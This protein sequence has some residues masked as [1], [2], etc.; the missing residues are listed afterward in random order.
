M[1]DSRQI[2]I[3]GASGGIGSAIAEAAAKAGYT[4]VAHYNHGKEAIDALAE[5]IKAEGGKIRTLQFDICNREECRDTIQKDIRENGAYYGIVS[6]AGICE[7]TL[8]ATMKGAAWDKVLDTNLGGFFNVVQ[9][10]VLP[11]CGKRQGRIIAISSI[12]G[13]IGNKGQVNYSASKAGLIGAVKSLALE[14][15]SRNIT[16]NCIAPG[17]VETDMTKNLPTEEILKEIPLK[18]LGQPKDIA[19]AAIF[20][21]SEGAAYITRQVISVNGGLA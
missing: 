16:V 5:K 8:F 7:D 2:L 17:F 1:D 4:V 20:L 21:L 3:T 14:L 11:M 9:P 6:N 12:S 13:I 10:A 19:A 15:A 18:R